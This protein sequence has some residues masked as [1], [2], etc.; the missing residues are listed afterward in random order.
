MKAMMVIALLLSTVALSSCAYGKKMQEL[1]PEMS[2]QQVVEK[3]GNPDGVRRVGD[4][5][6]WTYFNRLVSSWAP[7]RADYH[8]VFDPEGRVTEYGPGEIRV[9]EVG[10]IYTVVLLNPGG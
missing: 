5:T 4:F 6:V 10:G 9:R 3:L 2:Q 1:R 8:V 7:D